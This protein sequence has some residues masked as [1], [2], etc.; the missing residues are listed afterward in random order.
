M[1]PS[2]HREKDGYTAVQLGAGAAK[3]KPNVVQARSAATFA[4]AKVEPKRRLA[5][6]R[7]A[8]DKRCR[9]RR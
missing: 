4:K 8:E 5:E 7:V 3:V 6:F 1:S 2:P 9:C